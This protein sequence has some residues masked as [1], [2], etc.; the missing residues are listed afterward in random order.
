MLEEV[1]PRSAVIG[2]KMR[3]PQ[4][5]LLDLFLD[6]FAQRVRFLALLVGRAMAISGPQPLLVGQNFLVDDSR[7]QL[8]DLVDARVERLNR[9]YVHLHDGACPLSAQRSA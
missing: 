7:G 2:W 5:R 6:T 3:R 8:A 1:Q 9:L 4:T